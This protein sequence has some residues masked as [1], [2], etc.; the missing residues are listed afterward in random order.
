MAW[1]LCVGLDFG[2]VGF[3]FEIGFCFCFGVR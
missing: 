1:F 2:C 3:V